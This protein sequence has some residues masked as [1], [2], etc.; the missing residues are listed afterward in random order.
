MS[1]LGTGAAA[2]VAQT[3]L[4]AQQVA[5][6]RDK[7]SAQ[8]DSAARHLQDLLEL[9]LRVLEEDDE[10]KSVSQLRINGQLPKHTNSQQPTDLPE[11]SGSLTRPPSDQPDQTQPMQCISRSVGPD[12]GRY[13]HL[14]IEA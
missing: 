8:S 11:Q 2:G 10:T 3:G 7:R 1:V 14:D 13:R 9:H 12:Q 4:Q 5:R 6:Q